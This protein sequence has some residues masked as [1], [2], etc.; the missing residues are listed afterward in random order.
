[1]EPRISIVTLG[2]SDLARS[3]AF[4]E[5]L[6]LKTAKEDTPGIVFFKMAGTI[7]ALYPAGKLAEDVDASLVPTPGSFS[8]VTLAHNT[9]TREEVDE[10]LAAAVAAGGSLAKPAELAF[11]GGYSGYFRDPDGHLWEVAH[12]DFWTFNTDGSLVL[13]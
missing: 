8:G 9:R 11:W 10:L 1:M 13:E 12:A 6:G 5:S 3:R 2:V 7:L 4:Y